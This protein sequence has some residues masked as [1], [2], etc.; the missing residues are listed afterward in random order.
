[1]ATEFGSCCEA[2]KDTMTSEEFEPLIAVDSAGVLYMSV[3]MLDAAGEED[4]VVDHPV[5]FCPF[6]GKGLQTEA[7]VAAKVGPTA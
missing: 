7:E 2:L 6:C 5:Y 1:M 4:N 3:G